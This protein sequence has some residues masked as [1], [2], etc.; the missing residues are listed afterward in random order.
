M[1]LKKKT[2]FIGHFP[3]SNFFEW[4]SIKAGR[5]Y[6]YISSYNFVLVSNCVYFMLLSK[7]DVEHVCSIFS[8]L[9]SLE[10]IFSIC[11]F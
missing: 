7:C 8:L 9:I 5:V 1:N 6:V 10:I 4:D 3:T 2:T 11:H